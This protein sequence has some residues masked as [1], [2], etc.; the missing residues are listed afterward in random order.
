MNSLQMVT[1]SLSPHFLSLSLA[2]EA[3]DTDDIVGLLLLSQSLDQPDDLGPLLLDLVRAEPVVQILHVL[4]E[5]SDARIDL[6]GC[7]MRSG[8]WSF[9][10]QRSSQCSGGETLRSRRC[11]F[12][13]AKTIKLLKSSHKV[14][15]LTFCGLM[16]L[17]CFAENWKV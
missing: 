15:I 11:S 8:G 7:K 10:F 5:L 16:V 6:A 4:R 13:P 2:L 3:V 12:V 17:I 9:T 14:E 1:E